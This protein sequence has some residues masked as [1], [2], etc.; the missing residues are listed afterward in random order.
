M[1]LRPA[2]LRLLALAL[3]VP[4]AVAGPVAAQTVPSGAVTASGSVAVVSDY[5]FRG[6]SR[7]AGDSAV[8]ASLTLDHASGLYAGV[9]AST[10][11]RR[12]GR[13]GGEIDLFAGYGHDLAS[14]VTADAGLQYYAFPGAPSGQRGWFEPFASLAATL[15]PAR[16]KLAASYAWA[17]P[18][19]GSSDSLYLRVAVDS[20]V[21]GTPF[22]VRG[23]IGHQGGAL[24]GATIANP[25]A[26]AAR[27][28]GWD[29]ALGASATLRGRVTLGLDWIGTDRAAVVR[30]T[31]DRLVASLA[32]SF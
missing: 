1:I 15:G 3:F 11:A 19:I 14:G 26:G 27:G 17:Q 18:V 6:V 29:Y 23:H 28:K 9:W 25:A 12:A 32:L 31:D 10:L 2:R 30:S 7:S 22:T 8:Q 4:A 20:A 5:R 16:L 24:P 13:G 21:P